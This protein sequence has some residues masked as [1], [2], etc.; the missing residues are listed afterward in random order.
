MVDDGTP[1]SVFET[2]LSEHLHDNKLDF[3]GIFCVTDAL[4][5]QII[6]SLRQM[7]LKVPEDV[8]VIGYDGIREF[9]DLDYCC[10]TIVQPISE[11]A[12]LCVDMVLEKKNNKIPSLTCLPITYAY[13]GTTK[14]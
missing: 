4:A 9:G 7:G 8:Q 6:G 12:E 14:K 10:S 2:F 3:D 5:Y 1:Y 11:I 13:G